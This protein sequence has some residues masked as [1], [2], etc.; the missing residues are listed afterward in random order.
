M[1]PV[2]HSPWRPGATCGRRMRFTLVETLVAC[3]VLAILALAGAA[4]LYDALL[5][6]GVQKG[7]RQA[8]A[9]ATSRL[10]EIRASPY[11]LI[12]PPAKDA[13]LPHYYYLSHIRDASGNWQYG[14]DNWQRPL[15]T[16]D[17]GET[18]TI[19]GTKRP[20][21]TTVTYVDIDGGLT[22][23]DAL[24][25]SITVAYGPG[26]QDVVKLETLRSP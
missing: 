9:A 20:I 11:T 2:F 6:M 19:R 4:V 15:P 23:H 25:V 26:A 21:T 13:F 8:L 7:R 17:P 14:I 12:T 22:S 10:E 18:V 5:Q 1:K 16:S 3:L 24:A